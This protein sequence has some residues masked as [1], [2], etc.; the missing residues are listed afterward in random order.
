MLRIYYTTIVHVLPYMVNHKLL[1]LQGNFTF[2][3]KTFVDFSLIASY[4][5]TIDIQVAIFSLN[6]YFN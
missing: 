4:T 1:R 6:S 2:H 5:D 3:W